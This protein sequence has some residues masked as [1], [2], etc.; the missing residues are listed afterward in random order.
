MWP[1]GSLTNC[2]RKATKKTSVF[3]LVMPTVKPTRS[4]RPTLARGTATSLVVD[5]V[6]R[7][8]RVGAV[9]D[10]LDAEPHDV[11]RSDGLEDQV[12]L[13]ARG[14]DRAEPDGDREDLGG[15]AECVADHGEE[16]VAAADGQGAADGEEQAR[17]RDLDEERTRHHEGEPLAGCRHPI[18]VRV[19]V[20]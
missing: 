12:G 6:E 18:I 11:R 9:P 20:T 1:A 4:D 14:D 2:G 7:G 3:G 8:P 16:R 10:R 19:G 15:D 17:P 13:G 5:R